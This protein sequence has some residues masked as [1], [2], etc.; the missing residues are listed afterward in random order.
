MTEQT[1]AMPAPAAADAPAGPLELR[2]RLRDRQ[3]EALARAAA[4]MEAAQLRC[5]ELEA[6]YQTIASVV[7]EAHD[8]QPTDEVRID[9]PR[10][11]LVVTRPLAAPAPPPT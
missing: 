10:R 8:I 5:K 2:L 4:E 9:F 1:P 3:A 11:E 6:H 7:L